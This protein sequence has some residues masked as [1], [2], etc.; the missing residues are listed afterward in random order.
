MLPVLLQ[1][2][3][4]NNK[5]RTKP[6]PASDKEANKFSDKFVGFFLW[7]IFAMALVGML[8]K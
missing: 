6:M 2:L 4:K 3:I 7:I 5:G 8:L 1:N